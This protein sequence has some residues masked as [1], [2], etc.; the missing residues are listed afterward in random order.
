MLG[1]TEVIGYHN[2]ATTR[3]PGVTIGRSGNIGTPKFYKTDF[4]AHNTTLYA[5]DFFGNDELFIFYLLQTLDLS[6]FNSGSA[7]PTLNR[8]YIHELN[9]KVPQL[10]EQ[11]AIAH[12]L[13]TLDDKID[14]NR[15]INETLEAIVQFFCLNPGSSISTLSVPR[16]K[17]VILTCLNTLL[18]FS[19]TTWLIL[20]WE[21]YQ[22]GW[23]ASKLSNAIGLLSGGTPS[24]SIND[25]WGGDIPWFT[26]KD[27]PSKGRNFRLRY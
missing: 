15:Q 21:K 24:T 22:R 20:S 27:A 25:Y 17:A 7:V 3:A 4:W 14:L 9:I 18:A 2:T 12:I 6:G 19:P 1:Q 13:G 10:S 5:K 26:A 16:W 11:K 23:E 8:N